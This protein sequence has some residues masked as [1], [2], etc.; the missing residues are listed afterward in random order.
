VR[1]LLARVRQAGDRTVTGSPA[2]S[3]AV[4]ARSK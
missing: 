2:G 4:L 3:E 1:A